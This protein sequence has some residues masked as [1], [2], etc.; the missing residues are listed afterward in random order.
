M[1]LILAVSM[2]VMARAS[3]FS[4]RYRH[5]RTIIFR[6]MLI[7]RRAMATLLSMATWPSSEQA[8]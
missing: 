8:Q 5:R 6:P 2:I 4:A 1:P 3:V 7:G